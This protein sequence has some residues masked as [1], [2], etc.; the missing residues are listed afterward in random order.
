[1]A[2]EEK[3]KLAFQFFNEIG[4]IQQLSST[5][6]NRQLPEGMLVSH[7]SVLNHL[8]RLGDGRTPL[9][10][11]NAFQVTKSTM[12]NTLS[13]LEKRE[14][15]T[16][17]KNKK[18]GRS[19]LVFLTDKG[20]ETQGQAIMSLAPLMGSLGS[21]LD[22]EGMANALPLLQSVRQTLDENRD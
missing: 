8:V 16:L 20:R 11:A 17:Q 4:I 10:I 6:F 12:T 9:K 5:L 13:V 3:L 22:I 18:D 14:L 2:D 7:F 15:I 19:K 21:K 1:M